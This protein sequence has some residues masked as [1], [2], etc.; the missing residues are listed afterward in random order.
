MTENHLIENQKSLALINNELRANL[1]SKCNDET[2]ARDKLQM[3]NK[4]DIDNSEV[5]SVH[6]TQEQNLNNIVKP[7][8]NPDEMEQIVAYINN[9]EKENISNAVNVS[10]IES[11]SVTIQNDILPIEPVSIPNDIDYK[12]SILDTEDQKIPTQISTSIIS[13]SDLEVVIDEPSK[14]RLSSSSLSSSGDSYLNDNEIN[15][16]GDIDDNDDNLTTTLK[17]HTTEEDPMIV[18]TRNL[19]SLLKSNQAPNNINRCTYIV[20]KIYDNFELESDSKFDTGSMNNEDDQYEKV[21]LVHHTQKNKDRKNSMSNEAAMKWDNVNNYE[22]EPNNLINSHITDKS[23]EKIYECEYDNDLLITNSMKND[24]SKSNNIIVVNRS[25][26]NNAHFKHHK[27]HLNN[28]VDDDHIYVNVNSNNQLKSVQPIFNDIPIIR[29]SQ[30]FEISSDIQEVKREDSHYENASYLISNNFNQDDKEIQQNDDPKLID[31]NFDFELVELN[32][33]ITK[34]LTTSNSASNEN[35]IE[36]TEHI[37]SE[38]VA[39]S[40]TEQ[41][42]VDVMKPAVQS[43]R[44]KSAFNS[45]QYKKDNEFVK[46]RITVSCSAPSETESGPKI[47]DKDA[48]KSEMGS[49]SYNISKSASNDTILQRSDSNMNIVKNKARSSF[50]SKT[51]QNADEMIKKIMKKS[52]NARIP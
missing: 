52:P 3:E 9:F 39:K 15:K 24:F 30:G 10:K 49:V 12:T 46:R 34:L 13:A 18:T 44:P 38:P 1:V 16:L 35:K 40:N 47:E 5:T 37:I 41:K 6:K 33:Q 42:L 23:D 21:L 11:P 43:K 29:E 28:V 26:L 45:D 36:N 20:N 51:C 2:I 32:N 48:D 25:N 8:N 14:L 7:I 19:N 4:Y 17:I 50:K 22:N 27:Q 31:K